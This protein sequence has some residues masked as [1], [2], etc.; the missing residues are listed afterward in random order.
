MSDENHV[1]LFF[2]TK[3]VKTITSKGE[4]NNISLTSMMFKVSIL[5]KQFDKMKIKQEELEKVVKISSSNIFLDQKYSEND[6]TS[7]TNEDNEMRFETRHSRKNEPDMIY[8][9]KN[10]IND[11][12]SLIDSKNLDISKK[13]EDFS[14]IN[15]LK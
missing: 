14:C 12:Y 3:I 7:N 5:E 1:N 9:I 15:Y 2:K 8:S 4:N 10:S 6:S 11:L 13:M